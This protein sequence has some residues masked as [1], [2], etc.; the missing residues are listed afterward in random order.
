MSKRIGVLPQRA[1][2]AFVWTQTLLAQLVVSPVRRKEL[3]IMSKNAHLTYDERLTIQKSLA[4]HLSFK[5]IGLIVGKD[6]STIS[7][8][9]KS[10]LTIVEKDS[11]NPCALRRECTHSKDICR[12]CNQRY[13][14]S[15]KSCDVPCYQHC[16]DYVEQHCL[17][18]LKPPYVCNGCT[19]RHGCKLQRHL[20]DAKYAQ[21]E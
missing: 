3:F 21:K 5:E 20:Y 10:H 2:G 17:R 16:P 15:C 7:K 9:V 11:Y 1:R 19:E 12:P 13:S 18:I 8:E 14:K 4:E 6:P